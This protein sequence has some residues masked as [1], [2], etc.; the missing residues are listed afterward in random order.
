[1]TEYTDEELINTIKT[2]IAELNDLMFRAGERS[3]ATQI[4][5]TTVAYKPDIPT[6]KISIVSAWKQLSPSLIFR[7]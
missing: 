3:I 4:A 5:L 7:A 1:M 6:P 2:K